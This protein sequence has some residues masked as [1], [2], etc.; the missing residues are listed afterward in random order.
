MAEESFRST[1]AGAE[2]AI[3][4]INIAG[5]KVRA[6]GVGAGHHQRGYAEHVSSKTAATSFCIASVVDTRTFPPRW[7]HFFARRELILEVNAC[8]TSLDHCFHQFEGIQRATE[9][10]LGVGHER[11]EPGLRGR[12]LP[13]RVMNLVGA[14]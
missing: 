8:G 6:V 9:S 7:P 12:D 10:G 2:C 4:R 13:L 11:C 1:F 14:L 5:E 3:A